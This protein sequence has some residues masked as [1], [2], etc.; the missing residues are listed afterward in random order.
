[1]LRV[2]LEPQFGGRLEL[3]LRSLVNESYYN[4]TPA[5]Y[6]HEYTGS[7]MY[8]YPWKDYVIGSQVDY[9]RDVFGAH[10]T[11]VSAFLRY[12]DALHSGN[13]EDEDHGPAA[14]HGRQQKLAAGAVVVVAPRR[15]RLA[16]LFRLALVAAK[17]PP[18]RITRAS[19]STCPA[20]STCGASIMVWAR[21]R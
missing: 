21:F 12:G 15:M 10:Y 16:G 3:T 20:M 14:R 5:P 18:G 2:G 13:D 11:R 6:E 9:G 17:M 1:M 8:S 7:L 19:S 4:L